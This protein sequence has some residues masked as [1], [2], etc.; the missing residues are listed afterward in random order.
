M[1]KYEELK[2]FMEDLLD[3]VGKLPW[4]EIEEERARMEKE[5]KEAHAKQQIS[6]AQAGRLLKALPRPAMTASTSGSAG[7]KE[8]SAISLNQERN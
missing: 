5:I 1:T 2:T 6:G 3:G 4:A 7:T 8:D